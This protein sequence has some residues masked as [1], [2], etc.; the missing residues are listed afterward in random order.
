MQPAELLGGILEFLRDVLVVAVGAE[1]PLLAAP[2]SLRPKLE[3]IAQ[4]WPLDS[5]LAAQQIL[6][7]A[8]GRLRGSPHGRPLVELALLRV[9]RLENLVELGDLV[10][11]LGALDSGSVPTRTGMDQK[12]KARTT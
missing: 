3:A 5:I 6:A 12:K 8:R 1:V 10:A 2:P 7:E 9:A 11:R 4:G